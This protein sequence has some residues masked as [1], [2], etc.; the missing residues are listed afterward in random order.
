[1]TQIFK[2]VVMVFLAA[3]AIGLLIAMASLFYM[4]SLFFYWLL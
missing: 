4:P 2:Y 3:M 1:M